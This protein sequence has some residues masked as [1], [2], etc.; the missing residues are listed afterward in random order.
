M[1]IEE[2]NAADAAAL[3]K[4]QKEAYD[5]MVA[6]YVT[7]V[8]T[9]DDFYGIVRMVVTEYQKCSCPTHTM[10][11]MY[12]MYAFVLAMEAMPEESNIAVL[13]ER[14]VHIM[15]YEPT[16]KMGVSIVMASAAEMRG[17]A[18][19]LKAIG[20]AHIHTVDEGLTPDKIALTKPQLH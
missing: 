8:T 13:T 12:L 4:Y 3:A 14:M 20:G 19:L 9:W 1:T 7:P 2:D 6:K 11:A 18:A 10:E 17:A 16:E 5:A 15:I